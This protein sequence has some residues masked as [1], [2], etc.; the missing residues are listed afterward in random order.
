VGAQH[1]SPQ[2]SKFIIEN[3]FCNS[4]LT[5]NFIAATPSKVNILP[6]KILSLFAPIILILFSLKSNAGTTPSV[7]WTIN[8]PF[9]QKVFIQNKGQF[10]D[11]N[12]LPGS[13][14]QY[15]IDDPGSRIF[16][17]PH[18]LTYRFN[19]PENKSAPEAEERN[20]EVKS[21]PVF[22]QMEWVGENPGMVMEA[23]SKVKDYYTYLDTRDNKSTFVA[24]AF[25]RL[26][27]KNLYPGIDVVYTFHEK[28]GI[29]Y[30]IILHPGADPSV[31]KMKY[32]EA[33][34]I[35]TDE[36]GNIHLATGLGDII[37]HAPVSYY[38]DDLVPLK[39]SFIQTGNEVHFHLSNY[40]K[41]KTVIIDPWTINPSFSGTNA[42]WD[43][44]RDGTGNI[45][46]AGG[47]PPFYL[48]KFTPT[49]ALT[50]TFT[51]PN[52]TDWPGDVATDNAGNSYISY[53]AW[54]GINYTKI[55]PSG[56]VVFNNTFGNAAFPNLE[57]WR[58]IQNC[59][60]GALYG[61]GFGYSYSLYDFTNIFSV[62]TAT[63]D[64]S[65]Y[66]PLYTSIVEVRSL[67][68][69]PATGDIYALALQCGGTPAIEGNRII[70]LTSSLG[71]VFNVQDGYSMMET[72]GD[73][74]PNDYGGFNGIAVGCYL[75]TFQG[76][77]LKR[78]DKNTG[79]Q[80]GTTVNV[81]G[82]TELYNGGLFVDQ[83]GSV[84]VGTSNKV[85]KYDA[86]LNQLTTGSTSGAVYDICL[87]N[88]PGEILVCGEGFI[89]SIDMDACTQPSVS[90]TSVA[91]APCTCTG[92]ATATVA[93][94]CD[95]TGF[96]F[97]WAP[98]GG[99]GATATDLCP[100]VYTVT[101]SD[102][103]TC[104]NVT[105]VDSVTVGGSVGGLST[106]LLITPSCNGPCN[107]MATAIP[108]NGTAPYTYLWS[109]SETSE[110]ITGLCEGTYTVTVSDS[111]GCTHTESFDI[112]S[113]QPITLSANSTNATCLSNNGSISVNVSGGT[114]PFNYHWSNGQTTPDIAG[115]APGDYNLDV[116][117][118]NG[119]TQSIT[120]TVG[121]NPL[122]DIS[123]TMQAP[124]LCVPQ[125][126]QFSS[127]S[128]GVIGY[129]WDFGDSTFSSEQNPLHTYY[130]A[131]IYTILL[132]ATTS[133]GCLDSIYVSD[134]ISQVNF[135][136]SISNAFSPNGD[137]KN[138]FFKPNLNCTGNLNYTFSIFNRWGEL[139]FETHEGAKGWDGRYKGKPMPVDVYIY[140]IKYD[141]DDCSDYLQGNVTLVL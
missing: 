14:I 57:G 105:I 20:S 3:S 18:G 48:K 104:F 22:V 94:N 81:V 35:F 121:I 6:M 114:S 10:D 52:Y 130:N 5:R 77:T 86:T 25:Q 82:G 126:V 116:T 45:Y 17:T 141:C 54:I 75:Y 139:V 67:A 49:G 97:L 111:A 74:Y 99:S 24:N 59:K 72:Q 32:T 83:C 127:D 96:S 71:P 134:T 19:K 53:G 16:F 80:L 129:Y 38:S 123:V 68:C 89:S 58:T 87:G 64:F 41:S 1:Q 135:G 138:D 55:S 40:D 46:C 37:D 117:D 66:L 84:Y 31:I 115:L 110:T 108:N 62:D 79:T 15:A 78:W 28:E 106:T 132:V 133:D 93:I 113:S 69:S 122:P 118:F 50:W 73:Y 33:D 109:N 27:Y 63:G 36:H 90:M 136:I 4:P 88:I 61:A 124:K 13:G 91:A 120:V 60:T 107:G 2:N 85:V 119:C 30:A 8:D 43:I 34:N 23:E 21:P 137:G 44:A 42:G 7:N 26:I 128:S 29:K 56:I 112:L 102:T 47:G 92:S 51:Y 9:R 65:N 76:N 131:G 100:G 70:K 98:S 101:I 103:S 12:N 140:Y 39:S 11:M 95:S 125:L